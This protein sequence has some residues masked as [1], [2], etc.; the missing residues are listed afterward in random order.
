MRAVRA[1]AHVCAHTLYRA[2]PVVRTLKRR[3]KEE[4]A[5]HALCFTT[6]FPSCLYLP[7][8]LPLRF[9]V[10]PRLRGRRSRGRAYSG[11]APRETERRNTWDSTIRPAGNA[12]DVPGISRTYELPGEGEGL[13]LV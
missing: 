1:V 10:S 8:Y 2:G 13:P 7:T 11:H 9:F 3:R 5:G 4:G 12:T 6:A